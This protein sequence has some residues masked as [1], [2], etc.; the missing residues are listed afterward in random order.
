MNRRTFAIISHPDAGKTT[1]T[2]QILLETGAINLAGKVRAKTSSKK[3]T[4]DFIN[5]PIA[6]HFPGTFTEDGP[7]NI[8]ESAIAT[9]FISKREDG[10]EKQFIC[11]QRQLGS[12]EVLIHNPNSKLVMAKNGFSQKL[13]FFL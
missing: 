9:N 8:I 4:S 13:D 11:E 12:T 3:T 2:E 7:F 5:I 10:N 6:D 1:L